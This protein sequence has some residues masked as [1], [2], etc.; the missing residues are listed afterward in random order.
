MVLSELHLHHFH[1]RM[2]LWALDHPDRAEILARHRAAVESGEPGYS[3]PAT[4]LFV[5]TAAAHLERGRCC[6]S[7]CRHCPYVGSQ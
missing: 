2:L 1:S 4:G 7:G 5:I 3:D 6:R